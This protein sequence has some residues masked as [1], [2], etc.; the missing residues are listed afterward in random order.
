MM[1]KNPSGYITSTLLSGVPG[2]VHGFST[3][4]LSDMR[5]NIASKVF[6]KIL[7]LD[8]TL[9]EMPEQVHGSD[10][11]VIRSSDTF[12]EKYK[13]VD[14]LVG[15][16]NTIGI[17]V[18]DCVPLIAVDPVAHIIGAAHAGWKGTIGGIATR[19]IEIMQ[20][21]GAKTDRILVSI[22]PH[23][24]MCCYDVPD[25]RAQRFLIGFNENPKVVSEINTIWHVDIG[26]ANFLQLKHAGIALEHI[27]APPVCTK[28]QRDDFYSYRRDTKET[29]GE[30]LGVIGFR[31]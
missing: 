20:K 23:I 11:A 25:E 26:Y 1:Q 16:R 19:L 9:F 30:M 21:E 14:G 8:D 15:F 5:N 31:I 2:V 22:G 24:G 28:C 27:D 3:R 17:L 10:V 4:A 12:G 18:A 29:F 7:S 13:G 6:L